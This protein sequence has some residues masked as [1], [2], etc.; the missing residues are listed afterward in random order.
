[1]STILTILHVLV[2]LFLMLTVLLQAG[3][4]GGMG[5]AFGGGSSSGT[6]FGG[7]GAGNF[8]QKLT[9]ASALI[10][11]FTSMTLSYL[12][13]TSGSDSLKSYSAPQRHTAA[14]N[15]QRHDQATGGA[16]DTTA[17]AAG[18][19]AAADDGASTTD[20]GSNDAAGS[21]TDPVKA[22]AAAPGASKE[23]VPSTGGGAALEKKPPTLDEIDRSS[24][25]PGAADTRHAADVVKAND[26]IK[27]DDGRPA[28]SS[29]PAPE[30][31]P[32]EAPSAPAPT[33]PTP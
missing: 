9:V 32:A 28:Q 5:A 16:A 24:A 23:L 3:K 11:V 10:F 12:A 21:I 22:N 1:M 13:S 14:L 19:A 8:L 4:G 15:T 31:Q 6:V 17:P 25:Q 30:T 33:Q 20:D 18:G 26:A 29:K 27:A 2:C 7:S